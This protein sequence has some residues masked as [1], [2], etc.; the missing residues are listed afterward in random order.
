MFYALKRVLYLVFLQFCY[1]FIEKRLDYD[2]VIQKIISPSLFCCER[3]WD[4]CLHL[5]EFALL[6]FEY[7]F[8]PT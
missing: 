1:F 5:I 6:L 4:L 8:S 3:S 2:F 7:L